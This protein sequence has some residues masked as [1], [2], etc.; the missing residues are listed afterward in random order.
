[1]KFHDTLNQKLWDKKDKDNKTEYTLKLD[2]AKKLKE[3]ANAFIKYLEVDKK[4]IKDVVITG[5]SASFNYTEHSD[6]DLHLKV[7][8]DKVH[9]DC[10][11]VEGYLWALKSA[12]NKDHDISIYGVPVEVYAESLDSDTV[13]NGLYSLWQGKWI[14]EP[15]Q[16]PPTDNDAAVK[17]KVDEIK[18]AANRVKDSEVATELLNKLYE[19]RK[20]GLEDVGEF[21]T[22]NLAFKKLRDAGVLDKLRKMKKDQIDKQLS[23]ESYNEEVSNIKFDTNKIIDLK[24]QGKIKPIRFADIKVGDRVLTY[25]GI[26]CK[27]ILKVEKKNTTRDNKG[28]FLYELIGQREKPVGHA[29]GCNAYAYGEKE[30]Q[31]VAEDITNLDII[32]DKKESIKESLRDDYKQAFDL[33]ME[34][35]NIVCTLDTDFGKQFVKQVESLYE[36][37]SYKLKL[38]K[39]KELLRDIQGY[40]VDEQYDGYNAKIDKFMN[41]SKNESIKE[42]FN[43][44]I[45]ETNDTNMEITERTIYNPSLILEAHAIENKWYKSLGL[46]VDEQ[47]PQIMLF[48]IEDKQIKSTRLIQRRLVAEYKPYENEYYLD[49]TRD[50]GDVVTDYNLAPA[51]KL[52]DA[53][54]NSDV[55]AEDINTL[56][57]KVD[58]AGQSLEVVLQKLKT[59][60][61]NAKLCAAIH[62]AMNE[63]VNSGL[64]PYVKTVLNSIKGINPNDIYKDEDNNY[65]VIPVKRGANYTDTKAEIYKRLSKTWVKKYA[66]KIKISGGDL[67]I[68]FKEAADDLTIA[69][70]EEQGIDVT[71]LFRACQHVYH[72]FYE[73]R[74]KKMTPEKL[75]KFLEKGVNTTGDDFGARHQ[76]ERYPEAI[77]LVKEWLDGQKGRNS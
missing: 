19:M 44:Y 7:D 35:E 77:K 16:I 48:I 65:L 76:R 50:T 66:D 55:F 72:G 47:V 53:F 57:D 22:E 75:L 45:A 10:P 26:Y 2:V 34:G 49:R 40:L 17:A 67:I 70:L 5:S 31:L 13:H 21:S 4:A 8:Y 30:F 15:K 63:D 73:E 42:E 68:T 59:P 20:A 29:C 60:E 28:R 6:L 12:F 14:D 39:A 69:Q 11:I 61:V 25:D 33:L 9:K 43:N 18:E 56:C 51:Q 74:G 23:L 24:E 54:K 62:E 3:I 52:V 64:L 37:K 41:N 36:I 71:N 32:E 27:G 1:M 38:R 46:A 58:K